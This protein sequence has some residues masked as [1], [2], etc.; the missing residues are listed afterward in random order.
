MEYCENLDLGTYLKEKKRLSERDAWDIASQV[1][2]GL[3]MMHENG[4]AHR[5]LKP[6]VS[7]VTPSCF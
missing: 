2:G 5:D 1:L 6:A 7:T 4:F 3:T